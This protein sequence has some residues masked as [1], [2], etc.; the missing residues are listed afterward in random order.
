M[1]K[2]SAHPE[3]RL[4]EYL[5]GK[6]DEQAA[7]SVEQH[8]QEC[9]ECALAA[10]FQGALKI[11]AASLNTDAESSEGHPDTSE[12]ARLFYNGAEDADSSAIARHVAL[13]RDCASDIASYASADRLAREYSSATSAQEEIPAAAWEMIRQWEDS[14]LTRLKPEPEPPGRETLLKLAA[15]LSERDAQEPGKAGIVPV[16]VVDKSGELRRVEMFERTEGPEGASILRHAE[17]S[18]QFDNKPV[19]ALL[20]FTDDERVVVSDRIERDRARL[21]APDREGA[22]LRRANYFIIED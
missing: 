15:L 21:K 4:F 17:K 16:L 18:E 1:G 12:L 2:K 11:E 6:L 19:H 10:A 9:P 14:S 13:C 8:L 7:D 3:K 5:G 22:S 20:D